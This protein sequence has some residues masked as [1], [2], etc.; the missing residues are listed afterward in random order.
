MPC[1]LAFVASAVAIAAPRPVAL[2]QPDQLELKGV[3][4]EVVEFKGKQAL[5]LIESTPGSQNG[6]AVLK[7]LTIRDGAIEF[8][9]ASA[10][11][12]NAGEGA[13]GFAGVAFRVTDSGERYEYFYLRPTNGRADDQVRRNHS[14]Q[15]ASHPDYPWHRLRK[16]EPEKYESYVD[17]E[18]AVWTKVKI[19]V[20]GTKARLY[21]HGNAQPTLIVNDLKL[22][23][24]EGGI[25]LQ[26]G[27]GTEA[28]FANMTVTPA[29]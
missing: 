26:I 25:A 2:T 27:P 17:L 13:R 12:A 22:G 6:L 10:P 28:H 3:K 24:G 7:G 19:V 23:A 15:Y 20:S 18:P 16:E 9:V 14:A 1:C 4:A 5:K 21:V 8:E 29:Q 11:A